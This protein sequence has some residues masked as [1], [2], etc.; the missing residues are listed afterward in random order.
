MNIDVLQN[1][2]PE[3]IFNDPYPHIY[4][5]NALPDDVYAELEKEFPVELIKNNTELLEGHTHRYF[6]NDVLNK[7]KFEVAKIWEDFFNYHTSQEYYNK[8]IS[9][10]PDAFAPTFKDRQTS[11][12]WSGENTPMVTDT[13]FVV[14]RPHDTTTRTIHLDNPIEIYA[15]LFY[16]RQPE[17]NS[18]GGEFLIYK[19]NPIKTVYEKSGR[20]L[21]AEE[22]KELVKTIPY[23]ANSFVMFVNS[24]KAAHGVSPR[25]NA[26]HDR[27]SINIIA[28]GVRIKGQPNP[29]VFGVD[30]VPRK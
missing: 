1:I 19:T 8:I 10:F 9:I 28:E 2:K 21:L 29:R 13:Q 12:R 4:I 5:E 17:D 27:L 18:T 15:G 26:T 6:A 3:H 25:S 23:K 20:E 24:N 16:L 14:H 11:I 30:Q 22:P 7:P